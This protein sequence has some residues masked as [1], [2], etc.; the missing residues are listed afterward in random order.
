MTEKLTLIS[1]S[2]QALRLSGVRA[3]MRR[4]GVEAMIIRD[5]ANLYYLT[6]RVFDGYVYIGVEDSDAPVFF[7]KRPVHLSGPNV[8]SVSKPEK[9]DRKS[10]V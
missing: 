4:R 7:V 3:S 10:V 2:E 8:H 9:I 5:F 1:E 6:G